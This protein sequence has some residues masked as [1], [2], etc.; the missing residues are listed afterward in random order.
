MHLK[1]IPYLLLIIA[2]FTSV[3]VS[4]TQSKRGQTTFGFIAN[5]LSARAAGLNDAVYSFDLGAEAMFANP[6]TMS[7]QTTFSNIVVG[8]VQFIADI[9]YHYAA[10]SFAPKKGLYGVFGIQLISTDYGDLRRTVVDKTTDVGYTE[11]GFFNPRAMALGFSYARAISGQFSFGG[12]IKYLNV[13]LANGAVGITDG[14][15]SFRDFSAN[16]IAYD[17]GVHYKTGW[18]SLELGFAFKNLAPEVSFY[19]EEAKIP[20]NFRM[21]ASMDILDL[22]DVNKDY[23]SFL[24][25]VNANRP[26][27]FLEQIIIGTDYTFLNRFSLR[28]GYLL[29]S[30]EQGISFG[31]GIIQPIN[32]NGIALKVDYSYTNYGAFDGVN[33]LTVQFSF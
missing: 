8:Q 13:D 1:L 7:R 30:E 21:A 29:P 9:N 25:S 32:R 4:F 31:A 6:A 27:D 11:L 14:V 10:M 15:Y 20:L 22:T 24:V 16:V 26:V 33:R 2:F 17:F 23:H 28:A 18:E 3:E 12:T 5:P 19:N